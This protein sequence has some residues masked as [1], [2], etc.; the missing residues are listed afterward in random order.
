MYEVIITDPEGADHTFEA[1]EEKAAFLE[2][3]ALELELEYEVNEL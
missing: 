1:D 3:V 2:Y